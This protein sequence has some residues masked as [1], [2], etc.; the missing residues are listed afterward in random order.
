MLHTFAKPSP[1]RLSQS[2]SARANPYDDTWTK[3]LIGTLKREM[4][5]G[6]ERASES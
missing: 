6:G 2:I 3:S 1:R 5:Q 4:L